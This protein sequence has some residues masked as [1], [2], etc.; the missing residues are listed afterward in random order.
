MDF[1][2]LAQSNKLWWQLLFRDFLY[3]FEP[4]R[5]VPKFGL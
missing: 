2:R 4:G 3:G 1:H 5:I